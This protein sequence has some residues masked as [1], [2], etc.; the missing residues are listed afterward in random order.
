MQEGWS[1]VKTVRKQKIKKKSARVNKR[2]SCFLERGRLKKKMRSRSSQVFAAPP[3]HLFQ[4]SISPST[5]V[6]MATPAFLLTP[7]E[8]SHRIIP[9]RKF[10]CQHDNQALPHRPKM[11]AASLVHIS[12]ESVST[13]HQPVFP[14]RL[15][16]LGEGVN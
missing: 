8:Q 3:S 15:P 7:C 10:K 9:D 16:R 12:K 4:S 1:E 11:E 5:G 2:R 6:A 14:D 13:C